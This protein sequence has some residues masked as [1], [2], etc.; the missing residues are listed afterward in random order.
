MISNHLYFRLSFHLSTW[1]VCVWFSQL[2]ASFASLA[3]YSTTSRDTRFVA[4]NGQ[5][6]WLT[7]SVK[8]CCTELT[9]WNTVSHN[10]L[11]LTFIFKCDRSDIKRALTDYWIEFPK[12]RSIYLSIYHSVCR[13]HVMPEA[14]NKLFKSLNNSCIWFIQNIYYFRNWCAKIGITLFVS[15]SMNQ[16]ILFIISTHCNYVV[17]WF[18]CFLKLGWFWLSVNV[19]TVIGWKKFQQFCSSVWL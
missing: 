8:I 2:W 10:A 17:C 7:T 18:K 6:S 3:Y 15:T 1:E 16:N 14:V 9:V 5:T 4:D 12:Q 11:H 19:F 13:V